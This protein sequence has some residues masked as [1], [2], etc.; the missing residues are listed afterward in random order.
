MTG[1]CKCTAA[2]QNSATTVRRYSG[3]QSDT[4]KLRVSRMHET[5]K[6]PVIINGDQESGGKG[7]CK[8]RKQDIVQQCRKA[9]MAALLTQGSNPLAVT[10]YS[11]DKQLSLQATPLV[12]Q[13]KVKQRMR[14]K[15]FFQENDDASL[16]N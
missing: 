13:V 9:N 8:K 3:F 5:P 15:R 2:Q 14:G 1:Y 4:L 16:R 12:A 6:T 7:W 10:H 11:I